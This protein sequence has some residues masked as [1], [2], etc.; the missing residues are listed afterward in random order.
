MDRLFHFV[1][2]YKLDCGWWFRNEHW[3]RKLQDKGQRIFGLRKHDWW[4][5]LSLQHTLVYNRLVLLYW[6]AN[7]SNLLFR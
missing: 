7:T 1:N 6:V 5:I 3:H 4:D 2:N